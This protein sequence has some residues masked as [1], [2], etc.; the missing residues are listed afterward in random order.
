MKKYTNEDS[1]PIGLISDTHFGAKSFNKNVF[2][3]MIGFFENQFF[4]WC[5]K[6]N[7]KHVIHN[8]DLVHNRN[9]IDLWINQ[10]IKT[11]FFNWF[12]DNGVH[13]HILVGNHDL[14][15]KTSMEFNYLAENTKEFKTIHVYNEQEKIQIGK[16]TFLM[17][18]W[19]V[20]SKDFKFKHAADICCGH[21]ETIGFRMNGQMYANDG[22]EPTTFDQ[23][24]YVFSGHFHI[25][26]HKK[27]IYYLGTQYPITWND[28]GET[29]GFYSLCEDF[30]V[31]YIENNVTP[32]FIKI[33]YNEYDNKQIL[34]V[35]GIKKRSKIDITV[36]EAIELASKHYCKLITNNI[37]HQLSFDIFYQSLTSVSCNDY[38]IETFNSNEIIESFDMTEIEEQIQEETDIQSTVSAY[39]NGMTFEKDIDKS[40]LMT[41]FEELYK[42][43]SENVVEE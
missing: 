27:N 2:E 31:K 24:K 17:V 3:T 4:P 41:M 43:S 30:K 14:Y 9:M 22:F 29:K 15:Y 18:P 6:N 39:L 28:F 38:K 10:Q 33:Y 7:V 12:E 16:Y 32:K 25:K 13:L 19:V 21:F 40:Y 20:N 23:F 35:A 11:R 36:E 8:G 5:L 1:S 37:E 26:S 34:Q 42:E